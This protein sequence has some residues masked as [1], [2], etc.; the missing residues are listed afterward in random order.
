MLAILSLVVVSL[1]PKKG[2]Q[3][4]GLPLLLT[5]MSGSVGGLTFSHNRGGAYVRNRAIPTQPDT[6]QQAVIKGAFGSLSTAWSAVLTTIQR[7]AWELYATNTPLTDKLGQP[8]IP[9][10][11]NMYIRGNTSL[12]QAEFA[13]VDNG[14]VTFGLPNVGIVAAASMS[15]ATEIASI[16]FDDTDLWVDDDDGY[17]FIYASRPQK[18][19]IGFFK[20]PYQLAGTVAGDSTTPP[21]SPAS[22][23][24]PFATVAG[25]RVF[26]R[27]VVIDGEGR[28]SAVQTFSVLTT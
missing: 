5:A 16:T 23:T 10:G 25:D 14:P 13:R 6:G 22:I 28:K 2:Y 11:L 3:M 7:T 24:V 9:T 17:L 26:F 15:T 20:G 8:F 12:L 21:T 4:K 19:S 1:F 27:A 18:P